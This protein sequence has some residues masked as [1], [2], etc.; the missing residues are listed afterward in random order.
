MTSGQQTTRETDSRRNE[1][2]NG[3][4]AAPA[5][6]AGMAEMAEMADRV[7]NLAEA[8]AEKTGEVG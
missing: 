8:F 1:P 2:E 7:V 5:A 4:P 3:A 6:P